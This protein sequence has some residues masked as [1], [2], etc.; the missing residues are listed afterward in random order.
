MFPNGIGNSGGLVGKYIMDTV[1]A[2]WGGQI[3]LLENLPPHNEDGAGGL[4]VYAPW[5]LYKD[6]SKLG[7]ACP[8]SMAMCSPTMSP[9]RIT[10]KPILPSARSPVWPSFLP[11]SLKCS[12]H[13]TTPVKL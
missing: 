4:H 10:A 11:G 3:P 5:W 13:Y 12:P 9:P 7:F 2:N 1:G 6:A 8:I